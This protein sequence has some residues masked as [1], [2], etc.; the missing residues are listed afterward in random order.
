M[1]DEN[2]TINNIMWEPYFFLAKASIGQLFVTLIKIQ[3]ELEEPNP[4][5]TI[6]QQLTAKYL[7]ILKAETFPAKNVK[8]FNL[9]VN[10]PK[11]VSIE[12]YK[13]KHR[14]GTVP[15][16][17]VIESIKNRIIF[18]INRELP[19]PKSLD[20]KI[21]MEEYEVEYNNLKTAMKSLLAE[22]INFETDYI[23]IYQLHQH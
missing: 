15:I 2:Y 11:G 10:L 1:F 8:F 12:L 5:L 21:T 23:K 17:N 9:I 16:I 22:V 6:L 7:E 20:P 18:I 3:D 13:Q 19:I 4:V 14:L